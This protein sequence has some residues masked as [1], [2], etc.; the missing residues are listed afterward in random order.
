MPRITAAVSYKFLDS[1][2]G[3][4]LQN[5][6]SSVWNQDGPAAALRYMAELMQQDAQVASSCHPFFHQLGR[7]AWREL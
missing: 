4:A 3:L 6:L 7:M 1:P 5:A 2:K